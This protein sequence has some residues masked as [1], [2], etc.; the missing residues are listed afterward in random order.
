V[1]CKVHVS[2]N[3]NKA[4]GITAAG[5]MTRKEV[6][7]CVTKDIA[8]ISENTFLSGVSKKNPIAEWL[9]RLFVEKY[10]T[11]QT[12]YVDK[13]K[14]EYMGERKG[15]WQSAY[16]HPGIAVHNNGVRRTTIRLRKTVRFNLLPYS[17]C[18]Q[19]SQTIC[20]LFD[21]FIHFFRYFPQAPLNQ[22][23]QWNCEVH[24]G[25]HG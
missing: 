11:T 20:P 3:A 15:K 17:N 6:V 5:G 25:F 19:H 4:E 16:I 7:K 14:S 9:P 8:R 13:F 22:W 18:S 1:N 12:K 10:E 21:Q 2:R 24:D 23:R